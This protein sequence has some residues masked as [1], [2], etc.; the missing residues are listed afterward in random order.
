MIVTVYVSYTFTLL[1]YIPQYLPQSI[2]GLPLD[3][4]Y[5]LTALHY[6]EQVSHLHY[7]QIQLTL[8]LIHPQLVLWHPVKTHHQ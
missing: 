1:F 8:K 3:L 6:L 4:L 2:Q 5:P 7:P